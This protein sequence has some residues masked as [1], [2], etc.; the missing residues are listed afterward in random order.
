MAQGRWAAAIMAVFLSGC[1]A[2]REIP[3]QEG[4]QRAAR[5]IGRVTLEVATEYL[6]YIPEG[7]A[8]SSDDW[9]LVLF[10]HGA[11]ERGTNLDL[12]KRHGPPK[13]ADQ[14]KKFPFILVSPQCPDYE[15]WSP[16]ILE[17]LLDDI[18]SKY[19]VDRSRE[20]VTGLS[21]GGAGTWKL[22]MESPERFAAIAPICGWGDTSS[23]C[24]LKDVPVWVFHGKKDQAVP[25]ARS[26]SLVRALKRCGGNVRF[27]EY[28]GA[29]HDA[30]TET[31][32]NPLFY[33][34][35]LGQKKQGR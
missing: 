20:Y 23:V 24:S 35:L 7:Y 33:D 6:L 8:A 10:L 16:R 30:W 22:A 34:W 31:Y 19:R 9:P 4:E 17:S 32:D 28:P 5:T 26:A 15:S 3:M 14:G 27:T 2:T 18:E 11:G 12:V 25:I 29:G 1:S 13:L 21:L